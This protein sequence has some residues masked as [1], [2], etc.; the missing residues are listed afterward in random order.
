MLYSKDNGCAT[1][2]GNGLSGYLIG[3]SKLKPEININ[4]ELGF[5]FSKDAY[6]ASLA[7]FRND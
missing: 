5:E 3:N 4:K 7:Y 2:S 1:S 6:L